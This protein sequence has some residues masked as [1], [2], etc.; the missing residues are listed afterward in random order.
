MNRRD[1]V[2]IGS[3]SLLARQP[4]AALAACLQLLPPNVRIGHTHGRP[5][6]IEN[7]H[8]RIGVD[9]ASGG[10]ISYF[11]QKHPERN[12]VNH[13]DTGRFIQQSYY[14]DRDGSQWSG[15]PWR[16]NPVQGGGCHGER[17]KV[18][19]SQITPTE[20]YAKTEPKL[21][22]TGANV[23]DA[24]MEEWIHLHGKCAHLHFKFTYNGSRR[25]DAALQEVPAVF[26]DYELSR[27]VSYTG[28]KPWTEAP[29]TYR[30]IGWPNEQ[31]RAD[32]N[33]AAFV[34]EN[35]WGL[36]VYFPGT[37][38]VTAYRYRPTKNPMTGPDGD[39]CS[40][41]APTQR[42]TILPGF[43]YSYDVGLTIGTSSE[44]RREF[45]G[46][47]ENREIQPGTILLHDAPAREH[48]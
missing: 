19:D 14:G 29:L 21:W 42:L 39:A 40:Y 11:S 46:L 37:S 28:N 48:S 9:L 47:H 44:I 24:T 32:E 27:L 38:A 16:W 7:D 33:W 4:F 6:L 22:A 43:T 45:Y 13:H 41:L 12:L 34:D 31:V 20:I 3:L 5:A 10:A 36:G 15:H 17:A 1:L 26:M 35:G 30:E 2:R 18:L 8:L 25:N 23:P